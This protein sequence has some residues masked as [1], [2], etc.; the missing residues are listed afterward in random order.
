M[1]I[2]MRE[3]TWERLRSEIAK[4]LGDV[5]TP[6]RI[7]AGWLRQM[8]FQIDEKIPDVAEVLLDAIEWHTKFDD[9]KEDPDISVVKI[10]AAVNEPFEWVE[11][12][13]PINTSSEEE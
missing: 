5:I 4:V 6:T 1:T 8:G 2:L 12:K 11:F 9:S 3:K 10:T 7:S 13:F